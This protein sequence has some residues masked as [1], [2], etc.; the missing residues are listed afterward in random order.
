MQCICTETKKSTKKETTHIKHPQVSRL[1]V[2][3]RKI[4]DQVALSPEGLKK[5][6]SFMVAVAVGI[7][8]L[9][10]RKIDEVSAA[11]KLQ[12]DFCHS[13]RIGCARVTL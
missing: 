4:H 2:V 10:I 3:Q 6:F 5:K 7:I 9:I 8:F 12:K 13:I 11:T 1:W